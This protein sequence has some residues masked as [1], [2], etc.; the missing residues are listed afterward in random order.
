M[1]YSTGLST[2]LA[3]FE[4]NQN[5]KDTVDPSVM[6]GPQPVLPCTS[7]LHVPNLPF[8]GEGLCMHWLTGHWSC[9]L[10]STSTMI[11]T[12]R[13]SLPG[14][15]RPGECNL[16]L[17]PSAE[18]LNLTTTLPAQTNVHVDRSITFQAY[19]QMNRSIPKPFV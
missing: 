1:P 4:A 6:V 5:Y 7:L 13:R 16:S 14:P 11:R 18:L 10:R 15:P 8:I 3:N 17:V 2:P 19:V 12:M 9:R